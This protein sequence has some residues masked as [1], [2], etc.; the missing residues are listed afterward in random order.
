MYEQYA[1]PYT[2]ESRFAGWSMTKTVTSALVGIRA[3]QGKASID[4]K[5]AAIAP[6]WGHDANDTRAELSVSTLLRMSSGLE[7]AEV[8]S[9]LSVTDVAAM[10]FQHHD[11]GEYAAAS[12]QAHPADTHWAYSSGTTNLLSRYLRSTFAND[13]GDEAYWQ[14]PY[15]ALFAP[16]GMYS[17]VMEVRPL[18]RCRLRC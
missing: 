11:S 3:G 16:L 9:K 1:S 2:K 14:F 8:Y 17:A 5:G 6:E 10:L 12:R 13:G 4:D 18:R 15:R 7:F